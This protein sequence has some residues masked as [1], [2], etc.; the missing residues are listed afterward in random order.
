MHKRFIV[1]L[2]MFLGSHAPVAAQTPAP[3][4]VL[5]QEHVA[6]IITTPRTASAPLSA[7]SF[8]VAQDHGQSP[9][10]FSPL[11]AGAYERDHSLEPLPPIEEVK[12]LIL[13]LSSLPL[14]RLWGGRLQ[15]NAF[16][17]TL[18]NQNVQ[19]RPLGYGGMQGFRPPAQ[20]YP[21]GPRSAR[22]SLSFNFGRDARTGR[23]AQ[24]WRNLSRI[25]G[26]VLN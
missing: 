17:S 7:P 3:Q 11:F 13:T 25:V 21:G 14:V 2:G 24:A 12:N 6:S 16:Q 26:T 4:I 10:R 8:R 18:G 22:L 5:G 20:G 23:P 1:L 19:L 15:L 9:A